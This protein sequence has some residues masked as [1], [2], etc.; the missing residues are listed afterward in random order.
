M[1][2]AQNLIL[3]P[4]KL[5]LS[6]SYNLLNY[7]ELFQLVFVI[8]EIHLILLFLV[9]LYCLSLFQA[10]FILLDLL[11]PDVHLQLFSVFLSKF[12]NVWDTVFFCSLS[13]LSLSPGPMGLF[14]GLSSIVGRFFTFPL[15]FFVPLI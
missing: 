4:L 11:Q 12:Y 15:A 9:F 8:V 14:I 7:P 10:L 2:Q 13:N 3:P 6:L 1:A 5:L